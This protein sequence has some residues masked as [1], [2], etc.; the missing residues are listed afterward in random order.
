MLFHNIMRSDKRRVLRKLLL[1]QEKENR[2]TTWLASVRKEMERYRIKLDVMNTEKSAWK[3][4]AKK[5][6][7]EW[8]KKLDKNVTNPKK[9]EL[10]GMINMKESHT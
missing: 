10:Y 6:I 3:G 5:N 2:E 9:P 4:H 8:R 1:A 7:N